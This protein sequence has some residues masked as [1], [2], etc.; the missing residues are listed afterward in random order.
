MLLNMWEDVESTLQ[1]GT[2]FLCSYLVHCSKNALFFRF[3]FAW[4]Y[5]LNYYGWLSTVIS[6]GLSY[7][8]RPHE[9]LFQCW[10][11]QC[12][13]FLF[14]FFH[15]FLQFLFLRHKFHCKK[16]NLYISK[17]EM[18]Q[19]FNPRTWETEAGRSLWVYD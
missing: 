13:I 10:L 12:F 14:Y 2:I 6:W 17:H 16:L 9:K 4:Y 5:F 15:L 11:F 7:F 18:V 8:R 3:K 1:L 19:N